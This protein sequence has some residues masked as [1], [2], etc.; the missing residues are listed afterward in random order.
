MLDVLDANVNQVS[1][2]TDSL[3]ELSDSNFLYNIPMAMSARSCKCSISIRDQI[4][5]L[6]LKSANDINQTAHLFQ[7]VM[8]HGPENLCRRHLRNFAKRAFGLYSTV[9]STILSERLWKLYHAVD[10]RRFQRKHVHWFSVQVVPKTFDERTLGVYGYHARPMCEIEIDCRM[11]FSRYTKDE[12]AWDIWE[13]DGT[14]CIPGAF[15]YLNEPE[16]VEAIGLEFDIYKYHLRVPRGTKTMGFQR[17]M[18]YS[19]VQ[20]LLRQ[21]PLQW[22][23]MAAVR[24]D[25]NYRLITYPYVAKDSD[26]ETTTFFEHMDLHLD[27]YM[28][29][30]NGANQFTSGIS[31]D[32]ENE[33][34]CLR[35]VRGFHHHIDD[36]YE[37]LLQR[38]F[39]SGNGTTTDCSKWY[40]K[41]DR[42]TWGDL[43]PQPC[44]ALS[45]RLSRPEIIH[46]ASKDSTI[47]RRVI[48]TWPTAILKGG[49][50]EREGM[51][52]YDGVAACHRDLVAP[53][54]GVGGDLV[55]KSCPLFRFPADIMMESSY[56]LGDALLGRRPYD[57]PYVHRDCQV[58]LGEDARAA[59][60]CVENVRSKLKARFLEAHGN[61]IEM[62]KERYGENSFFCRGVVND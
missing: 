44:P 14:I 15:G 47:R 59:W 41:E 48:Y 29:N 18:F 24:D 34:T 54:R 22:A 20:Q 53:K 13:R 4:N 50:L 12:K 32:N 43:V 21:D 11:I 2:D 19:P 45:F 5:Q 16:I 46:G 39:S 40:S 37:R 58:L 10:R 61:F 38:G 6:P 52:D 62:E 57:D 25:G 31:L 17:N 42:E 26:T 7:D 23:L 55:K 3:S 27:S 9:K 30:G 49:K 56:P 51:L 1:A 35:T 8:F 36:W 60:K 33:D 28:E